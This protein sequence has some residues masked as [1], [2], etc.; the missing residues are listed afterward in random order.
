MTSHFARAE[1]ACDGATNCL[2]ASSASNNKAFEHSSRLRRRA[3]GRA[4]SAAQLRDEAEFC[5]QRALCELC[6]I[7]CLDESFSDTVVGECREF[8]TVSVQGHG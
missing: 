5:G 7:Y 2:A 4:F 3:R 6:D 1:L 8:A